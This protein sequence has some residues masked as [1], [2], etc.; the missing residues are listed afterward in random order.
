MNKEDFPLLQNRDITYLDSACMSLKPE[1]V[2]E[3]VDRYYREFSACPGRSGHSLSRQT[4]EMID[5]SRRKVADFI[6]AEESEVAFTSGTT[7][8]LN[9]TAN[10]LD[11]GKVVVS[12]KEH[13]SNLVPWQDR[14]ITALDT[15]NGLDI[16]KL[17][18]AVDDD[19]VVSL[20]HRSNIDGSELP[21]EEVSEVVHDNG[22]VLVVDAAQSVSHTSVSVEDTGADI[23]AFSGHKAL[24][25]TGTGV[26]YV[27]EEMQDKFRKVKT[28][29]G[30][31]N[32]TS[33]RTSDFRSF[34]HC[35]EAGLPN[36]AGIIGLGAAVDYLENIGMDRIQ[37]HEKRL[38][39]LMR[40]KAAGVEGLQ[41]LGDR[42]EGVFSFAFE[43]IGSHQVAEILDTKNIA[44]RS[45]RHCVHSW[46]NSKE[47][48]PSFRA[49][50][51]LYNDR[52]D[53]EEFFSAVE[54]ISVLN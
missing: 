3:A 25:P 31:V 46:F 13:N 51:H 30:A 47:L 45:G 18:K 34:P 4:T 49:S 44:V 32:D 53:I 29:G 52:E 48:Q 21:L 9:L 54:E 22:G 28:G 27:S 2:L 19:A 38:S 37:E 23:L 16:A 36:A 11:Q 50:L 26:L 17:E 41:V 15:E 14:E 33:F 5:E 43:N 10:A 12:D 6:D 7:E 1:Q 40:K 42:G 20:H 39:E 24:G 35:V 8:A